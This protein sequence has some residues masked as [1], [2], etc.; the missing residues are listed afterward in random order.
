MNKDTVLISVIIPTY[1]R[2][3]ELEN[4]LISL[5]NQI[6]KKFEIIIVDDGS[7]IDI[8]PVVNKFLHLDIKY[9]KIK[10]SE[11]G[12]ARNYGSSKASGNYLNF[13]DSDD[14]ALNN[15]IQEAY[16]FINKSD[17]SNLFHLSYQIYNNN[18][19]NNNKKVVK[20]IFFKQ[21]SN[22]KIFNGNFISLNSVF[23]KK[24]IFDK[25]KFNENRLIAGTEDWELWIRLFKTNK[26]YSIPI[27]TS[28]INNN[29]NR[30][31]SNNKYDELKLRF[32]IL[33]EIFNDKKKHNLN[34]YELNLIKSELY[35]YLA[36][37]SAIDLNRSMLR[38][39]K[40]ILLSI[41]YNYYKIFTYR[42][43]AIIKKL[44]IKK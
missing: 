21:N 35:M 2:I 40:L 4:L 5:S 39:L 19:N 26:I 38:T 20:K 10:N 31:V 24:N 42:F 15:H 11:R 13:F 30:S 34:N 18:N 36:L 7:N 17:S 23:I 9:F 3:D 32:E 16:N 8:Y 28:Q 22:K 12:A 6:L 37:F 25:Y 44:I 27:I 41:S 43:F 29:S 14:I 1:N 33:L